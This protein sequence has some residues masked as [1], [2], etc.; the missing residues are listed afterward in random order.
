MTEKPRKMPYPKLPPKREYHE[1]Y[2]KPDMPK[3]HPHPYFHCDM[4]VLKQMYCHMKAC[5][6]Y[7]MEMFRRL[8]C[9]CL[10]CCK[11]RRRH[12]PCNPHRT[13]DP[14]DY[15]SSDRYYES[16]SSHAHYRAQTQEDE[17]STINQ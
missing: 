14:N 7:E 12:N 10:K 3:H 13:Y 11:P 8:M 9:E 6:R 1:H 17:S 15:E 4:R 5:H 16:S 2:P